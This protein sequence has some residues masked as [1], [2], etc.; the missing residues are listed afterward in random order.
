MG[1]WVRPS[2][3]ESVHVCVH[4]VM[5]CVRG[6][7]CRT[8]KVFTRSGHK[9]SVMHYVRGVLC[10]TLGVFTRSGYKY[11]SCKRNV[12]IHLLRLLSYQYSDLCRRCASNKTGPVKGCTKQAGHNPNPLNSTLATVFWRSAATHARANGWFDRIFDYTC[13]AFHGVLMCC[14]HGSWC[15]DVL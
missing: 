8:L 4:S 6:A 2:Q 13:G 3:C 9:Y 7:W 1:R 10:R 14:E 12:Q 11:S 15:A 5:H